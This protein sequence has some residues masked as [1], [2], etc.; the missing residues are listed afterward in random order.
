MIAFRPRPR[1]TTT[2]WC[3]TILDEASQLK[4]SGP[5]IKFQGISSGISLQR[6]SSSECYDN[7]RRLPAYSAMPALANQPDFGGTIG[8]SLVRAAVRLPYRHQ[9]GPAVLPILSPILRQRVQLLSSG[10][11]DPWIRLLTYD[12]SKVPRLIEIAQS[13]NLEPHPRLR[14]RSRSIRTT[15][16]RSGIAGSTQRRYRLSSSWSRLACSFASCSVLTTK[17]APATGGRVGEVGR[18]NQQILRH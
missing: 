14:G 18:L 16:W 15:T 5:A 17:T 9:P 1:Q 10:S 8:S 12:I 4:K 13:G 7:P 3:K 2:C 6:T 11:N